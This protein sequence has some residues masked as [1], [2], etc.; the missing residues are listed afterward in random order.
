ML[1]FFW[2]V[3]DG[4]YRLRMD[5]LR[6][7]EQ[8]WAQKVPPSRTFWTCSQWRLNSRGN[9]SAQ[10]GETEQG[11]SLCAASSRK[12]TT[13]APCSRDQVSPLSHGRPFTHRGREQWAMTDGRKCSGARSERTPREIRPVVPVEEVKLGLE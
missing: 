2:K 9:S 13:G 7:N 6:V 10:R 5:E 1:W 8:F 3:C 12:E 11:S 4:V